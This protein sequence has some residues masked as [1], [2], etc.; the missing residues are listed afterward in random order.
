MR[1]IKHTT[2]A[3]T[4]ISNKDVKEWIKAKKVTECLDGGNCSR[5]DIFF[6]MIGILQDAWLL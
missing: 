2:L 6:I 4:A 5:D 3:K 1:Y